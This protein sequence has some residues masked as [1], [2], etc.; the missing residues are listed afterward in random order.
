M[1]AQEKRKLI[2]EYVR[3]E[4]EIATFYKQEEELRAEAAKAC[5]YKVEQLLQI[6][7]RDTG[8]RH[9]AY[10]RRIDGIVHDH[11]AG[12]A[13]RLARCRKNGRLI[14]GQFTMTDKTILGREITSI[15]LPR[16]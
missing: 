6:E 15:K 14:G 9:W 4:R 1:K 11:H 3:L 10:I 16:E 5:P 8:R 2:K 7:E 12:W 13:I